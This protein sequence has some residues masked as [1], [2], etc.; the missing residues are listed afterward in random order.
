MKSCGFLALELLGFL[1]KVCNPSQKPLDFRKVIHIQA[2]FY[3]TL[4]V[5]CKQQPKIKHNASLVK[6]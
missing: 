1:L 3:I 4:P 2:V 6:T 5:D